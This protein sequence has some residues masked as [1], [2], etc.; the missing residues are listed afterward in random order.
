MITD[1][2]TPPVAI[3]LVT[4]TADLLVARVAPPD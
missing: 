2:S 1:V 4:R 3:H